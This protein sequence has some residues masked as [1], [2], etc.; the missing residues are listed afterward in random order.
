MDHRVTIL[1]VIEEYVE[2]RG[3]AW[4][5]GGEGVRVR[6]VRVGEGGRVVRV[7]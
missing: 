7:A 3:L 1:T 2:Y 6:G 5:G 4:G